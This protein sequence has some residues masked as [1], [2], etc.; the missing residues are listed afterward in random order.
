MAETTG[1][2][3]RVAKVEDIPI[4][5][6]FQV[7]MAKETEDLELKLDVVTKGVGAA[8]KKKVSA[9]YYV[10]VENGTEEVIGSLMYTEEW[11]DWRNG[12]FWW[13][14]SVYVI[15]RWRR[16]GVFTSLYQHLKQMV[17]ES[18]AQPEDED[19]PRALG[20]RLYA[21]ND[22]ER[23]LATYKKLGMV[24]THYKLLE[25]EVAFDEK[26]E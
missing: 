16:K 26:K 25:W 12:Y 19:N 14:E 3:I 5:S 7:K 22:N 20:L 13:I 4:I 6:D 11:S 24:V 1:F 8:V 23:A 18:S 10:A 15:P 17:L 9:T 2:S 21:E